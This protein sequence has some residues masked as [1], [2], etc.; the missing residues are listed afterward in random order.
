MTT[1]ITFETLDEMAQTHGGTTIYVDRL[2]MHGYTR[3]DRT[4][5]ELAQVMKPDESIVWSCIDLEAESGENDLQPFATGTMRE[6]VQ[7]M[8]GRV[9]YGA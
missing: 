9:L 2:G 6:C 8:A 3:N 7:W 4:R 5:F 1:W